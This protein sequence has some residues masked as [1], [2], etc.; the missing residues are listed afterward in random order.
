MHGSIAETIHQQNLD[1][2]LGNINIVD[3]TARYCT[4]VKNNIIARIKMVPDGIF[5]EGKQLSS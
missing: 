4:C 2:L 1:V 3:V 5:S